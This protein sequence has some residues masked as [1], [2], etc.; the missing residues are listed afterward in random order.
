MLRFYNHYI[1]RRNLPCSSASDVVTL[2]EIAERLVAVRAREDAVDAMNL[3]VLTQLH[4]HVV[5]LT[6]HRAR[7]V[8][9]GAVRL[10]VTRERRVVDETLA[11]DVT[12]Q[13]ATAAVLRVTQLVVGEL[14]LGVEALVAQVTAAATQ[15]E[16]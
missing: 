14:L 16:H 11:T 3:G 4:H 2:T 15:T 10:H 9:V 12:R 8:L 13:Q 1:K 7:V 6:T 5:A